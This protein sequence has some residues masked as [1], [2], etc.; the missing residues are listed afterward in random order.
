MT[1][2]FGRNLELDKAENPGARAFQVRG[3]FGHVGI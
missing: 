1:S 3:Q 2:K